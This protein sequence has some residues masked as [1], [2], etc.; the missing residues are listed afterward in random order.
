MFLRKVTEA[1]LKAE[2]G[3]IKAEVKNREK[4]RELLM[5]PERKIKNTG[6]RKNTSF[7]ETRRNEE[8]MFID[9]SISSCPFS[10]F[11]VK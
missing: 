9:L 1:L 3:S 8:T 6:R 5:D 7:S 4:R 2:R 11:T 10:T